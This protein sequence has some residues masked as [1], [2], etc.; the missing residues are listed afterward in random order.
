MKLSVFLYVNRETFQIKWKSILFPWKTQ[1]GDQ[2]TKTH[3]EKK[4]K[5]QPCKLQFLEH[6]VWEQGVE[7]GFL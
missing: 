5:L 2:S 3:G 1:Q 4:D 7:Q 6:L